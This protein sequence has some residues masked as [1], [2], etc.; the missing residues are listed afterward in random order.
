MYHNTNTEKV[1]NNIAN[2]EVYNNWN[3]A[4]LPHYKEEFSTNF[5][6]PINYDDYPNPNAGMG[7]DS[8]FTYPMM[9]HKNYS[10]PFR[11]TKTYISLY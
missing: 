5:S 7:R 8:Y 3:I 6:L 11:F 9:F 10:F 1:V 4:A 2:Y